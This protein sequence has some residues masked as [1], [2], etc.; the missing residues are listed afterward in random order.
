MAK[1]KANID[2]KTLNELEKSLLEK[3]KEIEKQLS[4]FADKSTNIKNDYETKFPHIGDSED[5]N[6][7]EVMMYEDNLGIEHK[8]EEDLLAVGEALKRIKD[9][10]YGICYNCG[11]PRTIEIERL[12]AFPEAKTCIDCDKKC[13]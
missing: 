11:E 7:D 8:L 1:N 4:A 9:G 5:E 12:K 3:K 2:K 6:A 10:T 13:K